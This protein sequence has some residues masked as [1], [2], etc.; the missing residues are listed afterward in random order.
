MELRPFPPS[1]PPPPPSTELLHSISKGGG[2]TNTSTSDFHRQFLAL[3]H[4]YSPQGQDR[5]PSPSSRPIP[6][7]LESLPLPPLPP[8]PSESPAPREES[9]LPPLPPPPPVD[10][11]VCPAQEAPHVGGLPPPPP[12][13]QLHPLNSESPDPQH[14]AWLSNPTPLSPLSS[15][16]ESES[17]EADEKEAGPDETTP[18]LLMTSV[19]D[20]NGHEIIYKQ[21][22]GNHADI[23]NHG[24]TGNYGNLDSHGDV[25]LDTRHQNGGYDDTVVTS[26]NGT[27]G[28]GLTH[29]VGVAKPEVGQVVMRK[30]LS[31]QSPAVAMAAPE[32]YL[33][34]PK[35]R[36]VTK[37]EGLGAG[38]GEG[39]ADPL[40]YRQHDSMILDVLGDTPAKEIFMRDSPTKLHREIC[41]NSPPLHSDLL[42]L[43]YSSPLRQTTKRDIPTNAT[44]SNSPPLHSD[45][46]PLPYETATK[47]TDDLSAQPVDHM[48]SRPR[49]PADHMTSRTLPPTTTTTSAATRAH[50]TSLSELMAT[51]PLPLSP[52]E[53]DTNWWSSP[54]PPHPVAP[55]TNNTSPSLRP[56]S[57]QP[58]KLKPQL[59]TESLLARLQSDTTRSL[60][61]PDNHPQSALTRSVQHLGLGRSF[62]NEPHPSGHTQ[63]PMYHTK[64]RVSDTPVALGVR[65]QQQ[66][67]KGLHGRTARSMATLPPQLRGVRNQGSRGSREW[68]DINH[69]TE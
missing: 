46:L 13:E 60:H 10:F 50:L 54:P 33:E 37:G 47:S 34:C 31:V 45:L 12:I 6:P 40:W 68:A 29:D 63:N 38:P 43:P 4:Q 17:S 65:A 57:A 62:S 61:Q 21:Q 41:P 64:R 67:Q 26:D 15:N 42:P 39:E 3:S 8:A 9:P 36:P 11:N 22:S 23:S 58:A 48:T 24:N 56:S 53:D 52:E 1:E 30:Q 25:V 49:P 32:E 14:Q 69:I 2:A 7:S 28:L 19:P 5:H 18:P 59:Q 27:E 16:S 20:V 51:R 66:Q 35:K 55:P 44:S